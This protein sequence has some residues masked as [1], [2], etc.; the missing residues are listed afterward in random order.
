MDTEIIERLTGRIHSNEYK[1]IYAM[2]VVKNGALVHEAYFNDRDRNSRIK[3]HSITK[4]VTSLLIGIAIDQGHMAGLDEPV[5]T[6][7]PDYEKYIDDPR[8]NTITI[9]HILTLR[10]GWKWDEQ[11]VIY[12]DP[13]N[14]HYWMEESDDWLRYVIEKP[15]A[16]EPGARFVY[17]TGAVHLLSGVIKNATG[18]YA[19]EYAEKVLFEPLGITEYRWITDNKG[20]PCTGGSNGGLCLNARDLA[21][22]GAMMMNGGEWNGKQVVPK[23]WLHE[24]T[25]GRF[26][27][28]NIQKFGYLW[29]S[30]SFKIKGTRFDHY[31]AS[32]YGGQMVH[33]VPDLDL[34]IV[35]QSWSRDEGS[36]ILAPLLMTYNA[37]IM[38][39][40]E[41]Q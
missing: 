35:F 36:D 26:Q 24:S 28:G 30:G 14:S 7:L 16:D 10:T 4:S 2:A 15:L 21:K 12:D 6:Y 29:W 3:T 11:S 31:Q 18:M 13:E 33:M 23:A 32:G 25:R 22:I 39:G 40:G 20:Y 19:N 1:H 37:A 27:V 34:I 38:S 8:K 5:M 9:E 41:R 17:N